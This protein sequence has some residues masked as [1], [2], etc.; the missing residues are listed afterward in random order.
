MNKLILKTREGIAILSGRVI[1][2]AMKQT[3]ATVTIE[4][5]IKE[6]DTAVVHIDF[7]S[8]LVQRMKVHV[9]SFIMATTSCPYEFE[10]FDE[11]GKF[12]TSGQREFTVRGYAIRYSGSYSFESDRLLEENVFFGTVSTASE[13]NTENGYV[14]VFNITFRSGK[15][16]VRKKIKAMNCL[17]PD[18][19]KGRKVIFVTGRE[20]VKNRDTYFWAH[21]VVWVENEIM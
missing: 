18:P 13:Y 3:V 5:E 2:I 8:D 21:K 4:N 7:R 20:M 10:I 12:A 19:I 11:A 14:S 17:L 9:G 6:N 15:E 16:T 1:N